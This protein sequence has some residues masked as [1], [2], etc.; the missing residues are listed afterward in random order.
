IFEKYSNEQYGNET[1]NKIQ[2]VVDFIVGMTDSYS[3]DL[4]Q[5]IKGIKI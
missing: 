4:Y 2:L 1:Y 5:K 3:I